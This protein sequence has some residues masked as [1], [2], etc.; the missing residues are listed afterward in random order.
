MIVETVRVS[1]KAKDQLIK[2]KRT[3]GIE[4]WN[5]LCRWALCT[6]LRETTSPA[7]ADVKN[8]SNVEMSWRTFGGEFADIYEALVKHRCQM[9]GQASDAETLA[10]IFRNHLHRGIAHLAAGKRVQSIAGLLGELM[11]DNAPPSLD[12]ADDA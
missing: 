11:P 10:R 6:S 4:H 7:A 12:A 9:D 8:M 3:T 5:V 1:Q 2:L